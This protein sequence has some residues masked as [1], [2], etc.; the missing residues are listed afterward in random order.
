MSVRDVTNYE[1]RTVMLW[2]LFVAFLAIG[3]LTTIIKF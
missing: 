3:T 2:T 1:A